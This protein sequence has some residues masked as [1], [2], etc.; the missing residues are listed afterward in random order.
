LDLLDY[1]GDGEGFAASRYAQQGLVLFATQYA[2]GQLPDG[3][4]LVAGR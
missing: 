3:L 2:F 4:G 1:I